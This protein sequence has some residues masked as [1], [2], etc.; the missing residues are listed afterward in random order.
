MNKHE[1]SIPVDF[2]DKDDLNSHLD[3]IFSSGFDSFEYFEAD[4]KE[5]A[6]RRTT[7]AFDY[8]LSQYVNPGQG[9]VDAISAYNDSRK[10]SQ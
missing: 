8:G 6:W 4:I 3:E 7:S 1:I 2:P 5:P 9:V 10:P